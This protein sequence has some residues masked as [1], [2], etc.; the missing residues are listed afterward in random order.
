MRPRDS[1]TWVSWAGSARCTPRRFAA[2]RDAEQTAALVRATAQADQTL[3]VVGAGHSFSP[4]VETDGVLVALDALCAVE[5]VRA[6]G[7]DERGEPG[8]PAGRATHV[9]TVGAGIRLRALNAALARH[10]LA[11][12]NLGDIDHQSIAGAIS[13]GTH[14]TGGRAAG[15]STQVR[16]VDLVLASGERVHADA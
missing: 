6:M 7:S 8:G 16:G 5:E 2:P 12:S 15:L 10:G 1:R 3:R 11:M 14:G 13:T 9:V 4:I